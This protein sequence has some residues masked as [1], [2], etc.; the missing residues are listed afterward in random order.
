MAA[1]GNCFNIDSIRNNSHSTARYRT[2]D[3]FLRFCRTGGGGFAVFEM[4]F[5]VNCALI[6][7]E[8][9]FGTG[10]NH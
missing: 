2:I 9:Y 8:F 6:S 4:Q 1:C 7:V 5:S 10:L 3:R